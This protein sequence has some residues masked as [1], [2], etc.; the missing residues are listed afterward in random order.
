MIKE[1]EPEGRVQ[2]FNMAFDK[3]G[4]RPQGDYQPQMF[5]VSDMDVKCCDCGKKIDQLRFKPDPARLDT[6]RC[7]ECW[8]KYREANPRPRRY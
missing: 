2:M 6:I 4:G 8:R 7:P 5:D 1:H 3:F